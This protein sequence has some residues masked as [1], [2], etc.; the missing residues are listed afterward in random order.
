MGG[1]GSGR[2]AE[3]ARSTVEA[4][5]ELDVNALRRAGAL[6][7]GFAA[8]WNWSRRG[9]A[10]GSIGVVGRGEHSVELVYSVSSYG[11][12]QEQVVQ[13]VPLTWTLCTYGGRRPWFSCP[14]C[15]RRVGKLY[16]DVRFLCRYC[17]GL[18]YESQRED[19]LYRRLSRAQKIRI[20]L[21]GSGSLAEFFPPK[22]RGMH[23]RTYRRLQR[24][25]MDAERDVRAGTLER[26]GAMAP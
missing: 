19:W 13:R 9:E 21:G 14:R 7:P 16:G 15:R 11:R 24:K 12:D 20:R 2:R 18:I 22:P 10:F 8:I 6:E 1:A 3:Y 5:R 26:F 23:W 17:L 4:R 25:A